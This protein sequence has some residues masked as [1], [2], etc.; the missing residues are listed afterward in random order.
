M[1][2]PSA[3]AF[4]HS[5]LIVRSPAAFVAALQSELARSRDA[6]DEVLVV[7]GDEKRALLTAELGA[8]ADALS[9]DRPATF[10]QRLGLSY[11]TFRRYL[12][13]RYAAGRRVHVIAE[14]DLTDRA[15]GGGYPGRTAGYLAYESACNETFGPCESAVTCVWDVR[16]H[17]GD[18]I[19]GVRATHPYLLTARGRTPSPHYLPAER[20]L[21]GRGRRPLSAAP[22]DV[23]HDGV[24][25]DVGELAAL[26]PVLDTWA[27]GHD[28]A[29]EPADDIV[30][31]VTE[32]ATNGLR[33]GGPPVRVRVWHEGDVLIAQC[34]D[35]AGRPVP[36]TAG[37]RRPRMTGATPGGRGLWLARQLAD[38]AE[39]ETAPG[40]TSVRLYFPRS[41]MHA[42]PDEK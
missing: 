9:W 34:D 19:D 20:Y 39:V 28:F 12:A 37:Y 27:A 40:R 35:A 3:P 26:R 6:Y 31:S 11:E 21:A 30:V 2:G 1:T 33:H 42:R 22:A 10:Y 29:R 13:G 24:L 15:D 7:V 16:A 5:A 36:P 17:P 18:V 25:R 4:P 23:E 38:L 41:V 8:S 32:V 14:P